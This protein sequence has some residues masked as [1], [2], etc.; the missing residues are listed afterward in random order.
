LSADG[1]CVS[2][3]LC[4]KNY[5]DVAT[6]GVLATLTGG[7][8]T[9][10]MSFEGGRDGDRLRGD[11]QNA[12]GR[13]FAYD[14]LLRIR[15]SN[16]LKPQEYFGNFCM[17]NATDME[18]AGCDALRA[19]ACSL[20]HDG[21]L[22][23]RDAS[24]QAALLYTTGDGQRRIRL[25]NLVTPVTTEV[26]QVFKMADL[27]AIVNVTMKAA[28]SRS[29]TV[30]LKE[31]RE[32]L[33]AQ[34]VRVLVSYRKH[35]AAS[36]SPGQLILP[37]SCKLYPIYCLAML[38]RRAFRTGNM[39]SDVRVAS[40]RFL[41]SMAVE[42]SVAFLYPR[43]V[44]LTQMDPQQLRMQGVTNVPK[45][46]RMPTRLRLSYERM[47]PDAAYFVENG[48]SLFLWLGAQLPATWLQDVLGVGSL[49]DVDLTM[50]RL[51]V[52]ATPL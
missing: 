41:K 6:L 50:R 36:A 14:A 32:S 42:E 16:H 34:C 39:S 2:L 29:V 31:V 9:H 30:P 20:R 4:P 52:R 45:G 43:M 26:A 12:L 5:V 19:F 18:L 17:R 33:N 38:K 21:K 51:P 27:D 46:I 22:V 25:H 37:E 8:T 24:F 15:T 47:R 23:D 44:Q 10:Y 35:C 49:E 7:D 48:V 11:V 40:M 13:T 3:F 1:I 28:I